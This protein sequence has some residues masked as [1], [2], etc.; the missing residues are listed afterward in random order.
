MRGF[1]SSSSSLHSSLCLSP[2]RKEE[3]ERKR[4]GL[5][6]AHFPL[7]QK[8]ETEMN[9]MLRQMDPLGAEVIFFYKKQQGNRA[10]RA[11]CR[12]PGVFVAS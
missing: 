3:E 9:Y 8:K 6:K 12:V 7:L 2:L 4:K 1:P 11:L 10:F 5:N